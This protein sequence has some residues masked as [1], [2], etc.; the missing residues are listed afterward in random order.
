MLLPLSMVERVLIQVRLP[1]RLVR[2][3][4]KLTEEGYY[5]TRTEAIADAIRHLLERYERGGDVAKM[6]RLFLLGRKPRSP[7]KI[8][9]DHNKVREILIREFGT[10]DLDKIL[11]KLRGRAH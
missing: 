11:G 7:G 1:A 10:D 8:Q 2:E 9:I 6:V 3:L 5:G 4:D